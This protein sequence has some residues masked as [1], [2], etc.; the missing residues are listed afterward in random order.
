M[1]TDLLNSSPKIPNE[2]KSFFTFFWNLTS[3]SMNI[4]ACLSSFSTTNKYQ[5]AYDAFLFKYEHVSR[6]SKVFLF[7]KRTS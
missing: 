3:I 2:C 6:M 1:V 5:K 4:A 7:Y